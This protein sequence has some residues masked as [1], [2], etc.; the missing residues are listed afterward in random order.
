MKVSMAKFFV[1]EATVKL[2]FKNAAMVNFASQPY[3][4]QERK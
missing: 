4:Y 2:L 1:N 3:T